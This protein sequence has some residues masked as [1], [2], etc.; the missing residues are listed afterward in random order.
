M[1]EDRSE[2]TRNANRALHLLPNNCNDS[3]I[4]EYID[5]QVTSAEFFGSL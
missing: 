1:I 3:H 2:H 4:M 5:L